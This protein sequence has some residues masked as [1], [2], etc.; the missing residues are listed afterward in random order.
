MIKD[1]RIIKEQNN[2]VTVV[3]TQNRFDI[4]EEETGTGIRHKGDAYKAM[5]NQKKEEV[6]NSLPA[7]VTIET[8]MVE[9]EDC[10][11]VD[12][13]PQSNT[14]GGLTQDPLKTYKYS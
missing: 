8:S 12:K 5:G 14:V 3:K 4:L 10:P 9:D 7:K 6:K 2:K 1:W 11:E 13:E